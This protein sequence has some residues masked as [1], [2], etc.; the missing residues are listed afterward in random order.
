MEL[1]DQIV[2]EAQTQV[3]LT[4]FKKWIPAVSHQYI[5]YREVVDK[6]AIW[7]YLVKRLGAKAIL[8]NRQH[9]LHYLK[10]LFYYI[11]I[12]VTYIHAH[13]RNFE[14]TG[15]CQKPKL[16]KQIFGVILFK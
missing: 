16:K 2:V 13:K 6:T 10:T 11:Q 14:T 5:P 7:R 12:N 8:Y 1:T 4:S 3:S 15:Y 9:S